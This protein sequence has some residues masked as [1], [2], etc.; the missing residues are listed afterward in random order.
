M[1]LVVL[2]CVA[3]TLLVEPMMTVAGKSGY[4]PPKYPYPVIKSSN[5]SPEQ[6]L[7][8]ENR[9]I[10]NSAEWIVDLA[11]KYPGSKSI[12]GMQYLKKLLNQKANRLVDQDR[13]RIDN[14][15]IRRFKVKVIRKVA[16]IRK[17]IRRLF[18]END[19]NT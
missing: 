18:K 4:T 16:G 3:L 2:V 13:R 9:D 5:P 12:I 17:L 7:T 10:F 11:R 15:K 8:Y 6:F 19:L 1:R 14:R